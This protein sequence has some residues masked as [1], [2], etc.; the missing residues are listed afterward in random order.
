MDGERGQSN[1]EG[2]V[3]P[4]EIMREAQ[5]WKTDIVDNCCGSSTPTCDIPMMILI[6]KKDSKAAA[7]IGSG[8]DHSDLRQQGGI[9]TNEQLVELASSNGFSLW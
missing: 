1:N 6:N 9:T 7:H 2:I 5:A 3:D 4:E 8:Q